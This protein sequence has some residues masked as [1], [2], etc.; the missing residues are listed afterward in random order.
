M[1]SKERPPDEKNCR[2]DKI[3]PFYS[4]L[5]EKNTKRNRDGNSQHYPEKTPEVNLGN[6]FYLDLT[7]VPANPQYS[8]PIPVHC[9]LLF[10]DNYRRDDN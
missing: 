10:R 3:T 6:P 8:P 4:R 1:E 9:I 2:E 7:P 5:V